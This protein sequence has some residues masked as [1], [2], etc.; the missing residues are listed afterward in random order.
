M[1]RRRQ[2]TKMNA[3]RRQAFSSGCRFHFQEVILKR[4]GLKLVLT[5]FKASPKAAFP[6]S[7]RHSS[8][9]SG[10]KWDCKSDHAYISFHLPFSHLPECSLHPELFKGSSMADNKHNPRI[11]GRF[12]RWGDAWAIS[13]IQVQKGRKGFVD[14]GTAQVKSLDGQFWANIGSGSGQRWD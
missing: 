10:S 14:M 12:P 8:Q 3:F 5:A 1:G 7:H 2:P 13:C 9:S 6:P 11:H 4:G